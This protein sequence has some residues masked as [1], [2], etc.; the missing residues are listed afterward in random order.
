VVHKPCTQEI[1]GEERRG[2]GRGREG[3]GGEGK[4][5]GVPYDIWLVSLSLRILGKGEIKQL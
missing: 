1:G 4:G 3:E 2:R 5:K